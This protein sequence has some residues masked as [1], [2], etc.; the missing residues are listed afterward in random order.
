MR[1]LSQA[2]ASGMR[3]A[4]DVERVGCVLTIAPMLPSGGAVGDLWE[5][6]ELAGMLDVNLQY[7]AGRQAAVHCS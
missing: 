6:M 7:V 1:V 5:A 3:G 2:L 4:F